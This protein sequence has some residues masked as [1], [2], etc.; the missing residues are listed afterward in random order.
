MLF[1][2]YS[3]IGDRVDDVVR[4]R[5]VDFAG[6]LDEARRESYSRAFQER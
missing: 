4:H 1:C 2:D 6:K 3:G 5:G